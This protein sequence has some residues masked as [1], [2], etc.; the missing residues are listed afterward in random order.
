[1]VPGDIVVC[2]RKVRIYTIDNGFLKS[3]KDDLGQDI[4]IEQVTGVF[5]YIGKNRINSNNAYQFAYMPTDALTEED[6]LGTSE[7]EDET[8]DGTFGCFEL[9]SLTGNCSS[10]V[11]SG[12][13]I[14]SLSGV[15]NG[16]KTI[17]SSI[18]GFLT[19]G[20]RKTKLQLL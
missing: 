15:I 8:V 9:G 17:D 10:M 12:R 18:G 13:T 6:Q 11:T 14:S 5:T 3:L 7:N 16:G 1:M 2:T 19:D 4:L 20:T